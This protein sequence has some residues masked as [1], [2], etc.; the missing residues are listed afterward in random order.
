MLVLALT[1]AIAVSGC[2]NSADKATQG[3]GVGDAFAHRALSVCAQAQ[4][5]KDAWSAFPAPNFDPNQPDASDFPEVG[6]WLE[7]EVGP[8]FDAWR[9]HLTA[10]GTPPTGRK[11]WTDVL[12]AV[13]QIAHLNALQVKAASIGDTA[14]FAEATNGLK[15]TQAELEQATTDAGVPKCADVHAH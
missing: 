7:T 11:A 6:A 13:R 12:N 3:P 5:S 1:V 9:D 10:L 8:T 4:S 14:A 2:G 15:E